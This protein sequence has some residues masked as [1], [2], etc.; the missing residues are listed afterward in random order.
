MELDIEEFEHLR[1]VFLN[2]VLMGTDIFKNTT[3][4]ELQ[5]FFRMVK[6]QA[7]FDVVIDGL[8]VAFMIGNHIGQ[9]TFVKLVMI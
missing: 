2:K 7:P 4:N 3:P 8:N 6:A 9:H 5:K 1:D